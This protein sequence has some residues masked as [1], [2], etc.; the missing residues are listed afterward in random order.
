MALT[1]RNRRNASTLVLEPT[2]AVRIR[3]RAARQLSLYILVE[4]FDSVIF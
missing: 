1:D 3:L 4:C 2:H